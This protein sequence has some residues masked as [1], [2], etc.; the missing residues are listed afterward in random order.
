MQLS[1]RGDLTHLDDAERAHG[2]AGGFIG[3]SAECRSDEIRDE[4]G[5][6]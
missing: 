3:A 1:L 4:V 2:S 6:V 5:V